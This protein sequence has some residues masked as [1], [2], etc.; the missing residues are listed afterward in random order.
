MDERRGKYDAGINQQKKLHGHI[1]N[2]CIGL[3]MM[4]SGK[5]Q[6]FY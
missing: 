5:V 3:W 1:K 4:P 6:I 2:K